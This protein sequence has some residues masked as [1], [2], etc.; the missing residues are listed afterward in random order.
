MKIKICSSANSWY[1]IGFRVVP[2]PRPARAYVSV[3]DQG[4][5]LRASDF[6]NAFF[7]TLPEFTVELCYYGYIA[8]NH[9]AVDHIKNCMTARTLREGMGCLHLA[10]PSHHYSLLLVTKFQHAI[11]IEYQLKQ[12]HPLKYKKRESNPPLDGTG[13]IKLDL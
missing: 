3:S 6:Y 2:G 5:T 8:A 4:T 12:I 11:S 13:Y 9:I 7:N 1:S 10:M